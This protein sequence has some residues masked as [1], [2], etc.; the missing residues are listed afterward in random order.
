MSDIVTSVASIAPVAAPGRVAA[1]VQPGSGTAAQ[2]GSSQNQGVKN[3]PIS[4]PST[5]DV[6]SLQS[7]Q[8][9]DTLQTGPGKTPTQSVSQAEAQAALYAA[10]AVAQAQAK[11]QADANSQ[12]KQQDS[13]KEAANTL[14]S[15]FS[16]IHPDVNFRVEQ[17]ETPRQVS[18]RKWRVV[19]GKCT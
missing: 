1:F 7:L 14:S 10:K 11:A 13:V 19:K 18:G 8:A 4:V 12:S 15:Y 5:A 6:V 9:Q 2:Q 17:S 3:Q 16:D